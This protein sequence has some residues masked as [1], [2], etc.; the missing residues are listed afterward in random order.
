MDQSQEQPQQLRSLVGEAIAAIQD[1]DLSET[2][3]ARLSDLSRDNERA[4]AAAWDSIPEANRVDLVRRFDELSEERVELNFGRALRIALGDSSA[5]VRQLAVAGL[6]EDES[7]DL[8]GRLREILENDESPDVRAQAAAALERFA[9][10]AAVG[11]LD[12]RVASELRNELHLSASQ[13]GAPYAVQ[14]RALESLGPYASDPEVSSLI[15]EAFDSAD[16]GLQCSALYAM[17]RSQELR[18]LPIILEQ[19]ESEDPEIRFEAARAAGLL[20][21]AD[22]LPV[23]LQA[24]R[25]E[26]AEVRHVAISSIGQIGGRGAVRALE[27]LAEDAGEA[28]L[29]LIE[30]AIDDVNTLLEPLQPSIS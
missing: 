16:H 25:D 28:D 14:R 30:A 6:W 3:V 24:A 17:G 1:G 11:S 2:Q 23:L 8:L 19:L 18:W 15:M 10:K 5:V 13:A 29:E 12:D 9:S 4:L 26:D 22:A 27:R 7:S 20:G 21:S